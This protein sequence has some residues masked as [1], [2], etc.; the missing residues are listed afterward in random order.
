MG[1]CSSFTAWRMQTTDY[2]Y[3]FVLILHLIILIF[4]DNF[5]DL[6]RKTIYEYHRV[7]V[8]E[9]HE[10]RVVNGTAIY[11]TAHKTCVSFTDC[12]SCLTAN[13]TFECMWCPQAQRCSDGFDR[14]RQEWHTAGCDKVTL[15]GYNLYPLNVTS[16]QAW[17]FRFFSSTEPRTSTLMMQLE[18]QTSNFVKQLSNVQFEPQTRLLP[19]ESWTSASTLILSMLWV[20]ASNSNLTL[21]IT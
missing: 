19:F 17:R 14:F 3:E 10:Q 21:K 6:R 12:Q 9:K 16:L 5:A 15:T 4:R 2:R 20:W 18:I 13:V 8:K 7:D 1:Y 11:F